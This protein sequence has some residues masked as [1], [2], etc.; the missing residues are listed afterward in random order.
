M[1]KHE[2]D[3]AEVHTRVDRSM[4]PC[5]GLMGYG[6]PYVPQPWQPLDQFPKVSPSERIERR[7]TLAE[8]EPRPC[9]MCNREFTPAKNNPEQRSCSRRCAVQL[10]REETA[11]AKRLDAV[12]LQQGRQGGMSVA[13]ARLVSGLQKAV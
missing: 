2:T 13:A 4:G 12:R 9:A 11:A 7:R 1:N 3:E 8:P 6:G 10:L 5:V